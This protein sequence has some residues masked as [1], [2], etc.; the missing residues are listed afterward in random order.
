MLLGSGRIGLQ[1]HTF[2]SWQNSLHWVLKAWCD[3]YFISTHTRTHTHTHTEV[4]TRETGR[5]Q[6]GMYIVRE[7]EKEKLRETEREK[8]HFYF[9]ISS[10]LTTNVRH[11]NV[12]NLLLY[13]YIYIIIIIIITIEVWIAGAKKYNLKRKRKEND[14]KYSLCVNCKWL[15]APARANVCVW[16][17]WIFVV[18][19]LMLKNFV[20]I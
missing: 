20:N 15:Y 12:T 11:A 7:C 10:P 8:Q 5:R 4:Y 14:N 16:V 1:K 6:A 18:K 9:P 19:I 17:C 2:Y 3:N 13:I